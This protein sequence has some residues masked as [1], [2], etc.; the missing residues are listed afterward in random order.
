MLRKF[1]TTLL[2][3]FLFGCTNSVESVQPALTLPS[4]LDKNIHAAYNEGKSILLFSSQNGRGEAYADWA[5]YL[6]DFKEKAGSDFIMKRVTPNL[7]NDFASDSSAITEFSLFVKKGK[8][9]LLYEGMILE[10]QVYIAVKHFYDGLPLT[11]EDNAFL[12]DEI[13]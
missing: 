5:A 4:S 12:P 11:S 1:V 2:V 13:Q 7:I 8:P 9:S 10:P 6:N 3:V